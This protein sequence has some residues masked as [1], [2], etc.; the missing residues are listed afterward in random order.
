MP[1]EIRRAARYEVDEDQLRII[2]VGGAGP[3]ASATGQ[4]ASRE[5]ARS[6]YRWRQGEVTFA[7][8]IERRVGIANKS[9]ARLADVP[10]I[11]E[12]L[13]CQARQLADSG[14]PTEAVK[15]VLDHAA[16]LREGRD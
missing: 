15:A 2:D 6:D 12:D 9:V 16:A 8:G 7:F 11:V 3:A 1:R 5:G 4:G 13:L 14:A 10:L